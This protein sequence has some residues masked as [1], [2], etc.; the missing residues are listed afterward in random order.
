MCT[1]H[2][3]ASSCGSDDIFSCYLSIFKSFLS[4]KGGQV[5]HGKVNI[6]LD[7]ALRLNRC[8]GA[9]PLIGLLDQETLSTLDIHLQLTSTS[10]PT[11]RYQALHDKYISLYYLICIW[12]PYAPPDH[13]IWHNNYGITTIT[14]ARSSS[15]SA[16]KLDYVGLNFWGRRTAN[17]ETYHKWRRCWYDVFAAKE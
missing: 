5:F 1:L 10:I 11:T 8:R 12:H 14:R 17:N 4:R 13:A 15:S 6:L 16:S 2:V 9:G 3:S 7:P